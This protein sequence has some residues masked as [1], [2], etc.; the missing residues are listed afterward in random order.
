MTPGAV[1]DCGCKPP[2]VWEARLMRCAVL[3]IAVASLITSLLVR[4][5]YLHT[6]EQAYDLCLTRQTAAEKLRTV[7]ADDVN[8]Q[9]TRIRL[10]HLVSEPAAVRRQRIA[11]YVKKLNADNAFLATPQESGCDLLKP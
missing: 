11:A 3:A 9:Q 7:T 5:H 6:Q 1:H 2:N 8:L 10:E 4:S